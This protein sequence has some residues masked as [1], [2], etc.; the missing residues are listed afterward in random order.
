MKVYSSFSSGLSNRGHFGKVT[1]QALSIEAIVA[2]N[3]LG[4]LCG[5]LPAGVA[6]S[7]NEKKSAKWKL[8]LDPN[9]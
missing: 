7:S 6:G 4:A 3:L 5:E 1:L 8:P 9:F 2:G